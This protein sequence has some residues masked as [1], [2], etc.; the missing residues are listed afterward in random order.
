MKEFSGGRRSNFGSFIVDAQGT[1]LGFDE[2]LE[3]LTGWSAFDV[4]GRSLHHMKPRTGTDPGRLVPLFDGPVPVEPGPGNRELTLR[5]ADGRRLDAEVAARPLTGPG[6]RVLVTVLR[7]LACSAGETPANGVGHHDALTDLADAGTF[8]TTLAREFRAAATAA[9]PL[10]VILLDVDRLREVNDRW[11]RATGDDVLR[12]IAGILRATVEDERHLARLAEDE[13]AVLLADGGRGEARQLAAALRSKVER[14][15]FFL[16][17]AETDR[18]ARVTIT[19]GT[20]SFPADADTERDLVERAREALQEARSMG[21]NRVWCYLR[22]PRVPIQVPVYFDGSEPQ[23]VG[24]TRDL[25]PSGIFVHTTAG[26]EIGMRCAFAFPL[27]GH[28][29]KVHVVGRVVRTVPDAPAATFADAAEETA[30]DARE[31]RGPGMGVEFERFGG[32]S[33][34]RAIDV[35]LHGHEAETLRPETGI[36][37]V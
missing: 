25:S 7:V 3:A 23:L 31:L 6:A 1:I 26:L 9:R 36:L 18:T 13:F 15:R 29:G 34:R 32:A 8:G 28:E 5:C 24:W 21:R 2:A 4:V 20:A 27:P 19:L 11:G 12:K 35:Y 14:F 30:A 10:S 16:T 17:T 37:S 22:R 33:D